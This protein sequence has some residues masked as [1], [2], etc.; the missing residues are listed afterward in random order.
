METFDIFAYEISFLVGQRV[1]AMKQ[2]TYET[3]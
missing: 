1:Q 2:L 3:C